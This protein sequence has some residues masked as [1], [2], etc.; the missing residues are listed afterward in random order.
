MSRT[1]G[2]R[3]RL[4]ALV[5]DGY[6]E[7]SHRYRDDRGRADGDST[8]STAQYQGW[9]DEL[10]P[11]LEPRA[12]VLDLGCG[13]GVP[14]AR[15]L[16]EAGFDVTGVDFSPTQVRRA[17][18]LVPGATFIEA[19]MATWDPGPGSFDAV[20]S[21]YSLIHVPLE[22]QPILFGRVRSWLGPNGVLM[23]IVGNRRW[24]GTEDY[25]GAPMFWDHAD[26]ATYL[27][28]FRDAGLEPLWSRFVPEGDGGHALVLGRALERAPGSRSL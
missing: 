28:W 11:L 4:R 24:T 8:E 5:R 21:F 22:E 17:R 16:V 23:A 7:I 13:C 19:D 18:V 27:E 10:A 20:V 2:E 6:D 3:A 9:I 15:Q 14:A 26:T 25:L 12:R 1:E